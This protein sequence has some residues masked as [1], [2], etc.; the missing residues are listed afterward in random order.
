MQ[1]PRN[2]TSSSN[3]KLRLV[4]QLLNN[5]YSKSQAPERKRYSQEMSSQ[6]MARP[7]RGVQPIDHDRKNAGAAA[8]ENNSSSSNNNSASSSSIFLPRIRLARWGGRPFCHCRSSGDISFDGVF[9]LVLFLGT[10]LDFE[11]HSGTA[12]A[13][14]LQIWR[15]ASPKRALCHL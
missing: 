12:T 9:L 11:F 15:W 4:K 3:N 7:P 2:T 8:A 10:D 1:V 6:A 5:T 13:P 14:L